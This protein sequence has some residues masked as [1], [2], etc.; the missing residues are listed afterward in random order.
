MTNNLT[1]KKFL[2]DEEIIEKF[3]NDPDNKLL[4]ELFTRYIHLTY[5]L[6]FKYLKNDDACKDAVIE[7]YEQIINDIRKY[8]IKHFKNWLYVKTKNYCLNNNNQ[9][10]NSKIELIFFE[11]ID[12][13]FMEFPFFIN[14]ST[15][16][17]NI[18]DNNQ[19]E[20]V[21]NKLNAKQK[22]CI[23]LFYFENNSYSEISDITGYDIKQVKSHLQNGKRN[24]KNII[25]SFI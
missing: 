10:N 8:E 25:H 4:N 6:C 17:I 1:N 3:K 11:Q 13:I 24:L 23:Q 5:N 22:K 20:T 16:E 15:E 14:H 9:K 19:M 12:N 18:I 7:I 2:K 21:I